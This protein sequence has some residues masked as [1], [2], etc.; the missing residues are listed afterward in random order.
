MQQASP[1]FGRSFDHPTEEVLEPKIT[2]S[3]LA[4]ARA[5]GAE[6]ARASAE[7]RILALT[8]N[9][10]ES[11]SAL[12]SEDDER[13]QRISQDCA[14]VLRAVCERV[15]PSLAEHEAIND[16][17]RIVARCLTA[18]TDEPRIVIRVSNEL[19]DAVQS[20]LTAASAQTGFSG[21]LVLIPDETL[22]N[23]DCSVLW[24]DG[25]AERNFT[26][27]RSEIEQALDRALGGDNAKSPTTPQP[28]SP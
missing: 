21:Q 17:V 18:Q 7:G 26:R 5:A 6:E 2:E 27:I 4:A 19:A 3:D 1:L 13:R 15:V 23:T 24:A 11:L 12:A 22:S 8:K 14:E 10:T 28:E 9:L 20:R 16:I 25:G